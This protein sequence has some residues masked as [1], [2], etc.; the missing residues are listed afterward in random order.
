MP[1]KENRVP[2]ASTPANE[3][4]PDWSPN[5]RRVVYSS[6][7][8]KSWQL[9]L[10]DRAQGTPRKLTERGS[11]TDPVWS[12]DGD[13]VA[14]ESNR[15]GNWDIWV[16]DVT[17]QRATNVSKSRLPEF[18]PDWS[19]RGER[20]VFTR[21]SSGASDLFTA[22][23]ASGKVSRLTQSK[24]LE[25]DPSWSPDGE[26]I[27]FDRLV[28]RD[29]DIYVMTL[30]P[31][32]VVR[33]TYAR[34]EDS[35][36]DWSPDGRELLFLSARDGDYEIYTIKASAGSEARNVTSDPTSDE[37]SA[38]WVR[39]STGLAFMDASAFGSEPAA[40]PLPGP[41]FCTRP[42]WTS[43]DGKE[44]Q[45]GPTKDVLCG[46]AGK[47]VLKGLGGDD[48]LTGGGAADELYGG[49]GKDVLRARDGYRDALWGG[50]K[51]VDTAA[52]RGF[53]DK[54][55]PQ[56]AKRRPGRTRARGD[57]RH[58]VEILSP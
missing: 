11:N 20:I 25:F 12:P 54:M 10:L 38:H 24:A 19:P 43:P 29:Y 34:G 53:V 27:A 13:K 57:A 31:R 6:D 40:A 26:R 37:V 44:R 47:D 7:L 9:Y 21:V 15:A 5:A 2:G 36:P 4:E 39:R 33:L 8:D 51:T 58:D 14:Y 41:H 49:P 46:T 55:L 1:G 22:N 50:T 56:T 3:I 17:S 42:L 32:K 28:N 52:D 30:E 16:Y 48:R 35:N 45:G 18:D 23:I